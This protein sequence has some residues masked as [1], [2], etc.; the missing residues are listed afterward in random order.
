MPHDHIESATFEQLLERAADSCGIDPGYWDIWGKHHVTT[1]A[2]RQALLASAGVPSSDAEE[3]ER[4]LSERARREWQRHLPPSLVVSQSESHTLPI[5]V[6]VES[7]GEPATITIQREDGQTE[8]LD[9]HLPTLSHSESLEMEGR[10]W[11]RKIATLPTPLPLGYH[12]IQ[13]AIGS[14]RAET[15]YI[16][17]P[18]RA[19]IEPSLGRGA[20]A[21]GI[22]VSLYGLRSAR[23]WGCG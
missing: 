18:D 5:S 14:Q 16:V 20:S 10:T 22:N 3:L 15:R 11:V 13:L 12:T 8:T 19:W 2:V 21:A 7:L 9:L 17:T 1:P 23:N 6:A 4:A